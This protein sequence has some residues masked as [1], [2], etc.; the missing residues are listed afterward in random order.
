MSSKTDV[1]QQAGMPLG[2][3][4]TDDY[5]ALTGGGILC[6]GCL[7]KRLG[8][9][10]TRDDFSPITLDLLK[11]CQ[12]TPRL[13]SRV[14]IAFM[15]VANDPLPDHIVDRWLETTLTNALRDHHPPHMPR[16]Y[17]VDVDGDEVILVHRREALSYRAGPKLMALRDALRRDRLDDLPDME[18][19]LLAWGEPDEAAA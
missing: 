2:K 8:R 10:L 12:N 6:I 7:E 11:G 19:D 4:D 1:W 15:A 18:V 14:G 13:L 3:M 9:L 16:V 17:K 5:L